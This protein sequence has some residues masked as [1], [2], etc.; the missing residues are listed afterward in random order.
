LEERFIALD[1]NIARI[2]KTMLRL[3]VN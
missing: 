2:A 3:G 1:V